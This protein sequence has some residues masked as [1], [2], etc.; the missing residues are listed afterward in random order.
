MTIW[1][2]SEFDREGWAVGLF[3]FQGGKH[4]EAATYKISGLLKQP[5]GTLDP[6]FFLKGEKEGQTGKQ[7]P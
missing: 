3:W 1:I 7:V 5:C 6:P 2:V 4:N